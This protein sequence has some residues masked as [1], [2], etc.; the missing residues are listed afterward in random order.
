MVS[1]QEYVGIFQN[2]VTACHLGTDKQ[3]HDW[4]TAVI[5]VPM[6]STHP[7]IPGTAKLP[8]N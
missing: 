8:G 2:V 7:S 5:R 6:T 3:V 4:K 1:L